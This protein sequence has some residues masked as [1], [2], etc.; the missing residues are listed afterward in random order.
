MEGNKARIGENR[1]DTDIKEYKT[2]MYV[3]LSA[4][5]K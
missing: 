1:Y 4:L 3:D 5:L 2:F